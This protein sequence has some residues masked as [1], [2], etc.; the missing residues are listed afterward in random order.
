MIDKRNLRKVL[1]ERLAGLPVGHAVDIRTYKRNR[2][3]VFTRLE[4]DRFRVVVKGFEDEDFIIPE[5]RL[6]R[7]IRTLLS[8][9]F[10]RS[11]KVRL[12]MLGEHDPDGDGAHARKII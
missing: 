10:P 1:M 3:V 8:R 5:G 4:G 7:I 12:Y 2:S 11:N 9:E 6:P